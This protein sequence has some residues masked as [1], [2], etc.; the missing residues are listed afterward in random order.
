MECTAEAIERAKRVK[1]VIL[2]V[3]GVLTD[4]GI[5]VGADGELFKPFYC[6]DGL[7]VTLARKVGVRTAIITGRASK[8]VVF[9]AGE[10]RIED[11]WQ[12]NLDKRGAYRELKE[13]RGLSDEE[14]A[15]VGDDV[16]DLP[17][18]LKVGFPIA[19]ADGVPEVREVAQLVTDHPG[20]HGA[21]RDAFEFI[22]KAQG[23]WRQILDSFKAPGDTLGLAQ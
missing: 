5:Y 16:L 3:D 7:G 23:R 13:K 21:V 9:R 22:L 14:I 1:C 19:V 20:G 15:Y 12:G 11:I 2:D 6:R 17:I 4:G 10:L 8:H 18:M